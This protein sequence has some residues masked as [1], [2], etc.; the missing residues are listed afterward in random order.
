MEVRLDLSLDE[1]KLMGG[2]DV[3]Y[4]LNE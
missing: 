4:M 3:Y 1:L 2:E